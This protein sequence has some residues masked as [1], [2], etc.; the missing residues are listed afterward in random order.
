MDIACDDNVTQ[1]LIAVFKCV[2]PCWSFKVGPNAE[3]KMLELRY[4][5]SK[6]SHF[7]FYWLDP[8][9]GLTHLRL[10]SWAPFRFTYASTDENGCRDN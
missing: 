10:Q 6:C 7:Y 1:G 5:P 8:Q 3:T 2:E 4:L 9:L